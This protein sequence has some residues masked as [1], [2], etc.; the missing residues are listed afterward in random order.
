MWPAIPLW[1]RGDMYVN[2]FLWGVD[3]VMVGGKE[4]AGAAGGVLD[5]A[6]PSYRFAEREDP[7]SGDIDR[8][9]AC[10]IEPSKSSERSSELYVRFAC[11]ARLHVSPDS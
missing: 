10:G 9:V 8:G 6:P 7:C 11:S 2:K 3:G 5:L 1:F 4:G